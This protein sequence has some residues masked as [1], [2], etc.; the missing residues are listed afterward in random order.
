MGIVD[1]LVK[2]SQYLPEVKNPEKEIPFKQKLIWTTIALVIFFIMGQIT[3]VGMDLLSPSVQ[4]IMFA[5]TILASNVGTLITAGIGPIVMASIFLQLFVGAKILNIDLGDPQGRM[6][7]QALQKILA[8]ILCFAEGY[9]YVAS[10][11][12]TPIG[13]AGLANPWLWIVSLQIALGSLVL[14]YFDEIMSKYGL[15][16]GI[17]LF[18]AAGVSG[19]MFWQIFAP[20]IGLGAGGILFKLFIAGDI[21]SQLLLILPI[22][23]VI[24]IFLIVV[25]AEGMHV[26]IPITMG[27]RGTGGRYPVKFLYVSNMPVILAMALFMNVRLWALFVEKVPFVGEFFAGLAWAVNLPNIGG[28]SLVQGIILNW[29]NVAV[30]LPAVFQGIIFMFLFIIACIVFGWFWVQMGNQSTEAVA[31]QLE[32][33]GMQ[34][35]GFRKDKRVIEKVLNRYIPPITILG[36]IFVALLAG[37]GDMVL[38]GLASGTGILLTVGIIYRFYEEIAKSQAEA[39]APLLGKL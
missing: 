29:G 28:Q 20:P 9:I 4:Q 26:N 24:A 27:H 19:A 13:G 15:G 34:I 37:M 5:Q 22:I 17:S 25:F 31:A 8:V 1:I 2:A 3:L 35:P 33:S 11:L 32:R 10:G 12:L 21:L 30:I 23:G 36:S 14:L 18:I 6:Q 38:S 39:L 7:F 16:S